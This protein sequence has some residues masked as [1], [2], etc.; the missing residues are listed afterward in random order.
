MI[1]K[2]TSAFTGITR[3]VDLPV[4]E[5][6]MNRYNNGELIQ[7]AFPQ[8]TPGQREFILTGVTDDEWDDMFGEKE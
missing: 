6:Q 2:R 7:R 4:T 5:E 3:E 8:L 1:I